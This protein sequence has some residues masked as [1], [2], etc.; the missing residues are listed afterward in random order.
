LNVKNL[1]LKPAKEKEGELILLQNHAH[2]PTHF[3][4][5]KREKFLYFLGREELQ[6]KMNSGV[7]TFDFVIGGPRFSDTIYAKAQG[8]ISLSL[9]TFTNGASVFY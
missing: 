6:K 9:M 8:K 4:G 5:R 2:G 7:K 1:N 3:I